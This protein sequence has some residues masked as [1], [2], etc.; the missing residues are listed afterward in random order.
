[1]IIQNQ[2]KMQFRVLIARRETGRVIET[3]SSLIETESVADAISAAT[4]AIDTF[5]SD[6]PGV[7]VLVQ[8]GGRTVWSIRRNMPAP[9]LPNL[10]AR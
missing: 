6:C 10:I 7:G 8:L 5:L 1:M 2:T 3:S 9:E 4:I